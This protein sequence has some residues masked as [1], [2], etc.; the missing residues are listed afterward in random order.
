ML[1][2]SGFIA[3]VLD[4]APGLIWLGA[5]AL[6]WTSADMI[7]GDPA[8]DPHI[9]DHW[10]ISAGLSLAILGAVI[11]VRALRHRAA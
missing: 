10:A 4:H 9:A 2:G 1:F 8:L 6:V 3:R 11:G 7:L 5:L